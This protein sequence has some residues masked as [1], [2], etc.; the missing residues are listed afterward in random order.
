MVHKWKIEIII[1]KEITRN[2]FIDLS[3]NENWIFIMK[4]IQRKVESLEAPLII[5]TTFKKA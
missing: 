1:D 4:V 2:F 3:A 5:L